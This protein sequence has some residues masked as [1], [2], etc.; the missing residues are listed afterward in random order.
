MPEGDTIFRAARTLDRALAGSA[1]ARFETALPALARVDEDAP[2]AGR[3]VESVTARGKHQ[4]MRFSARPGG[5]GGPLVL[6]THMRMSGSW[7]LYRHGERWQRPRGAMR[8]LVETAAWVAVGFDVPVAEWLD[9]RGL[10]RQRE[11]RRLG[12]D[13]LAADFD[14][15]EA[16]R[17]L[18][19][20]DAAAVGDALLDQ[21]ALAG[22]GNVFKSEILFVAGVSPFRSVA[23]LS[24]EEL[25]SIVAVSRRLLRANAGPGEDGV[26]W[27]AGAR[28]TTGAANPAAALWVYGR[29]GDPCRRCATPVAYRKQGP[30]ARG[31]YWC[32]RC[33]PG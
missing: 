12:P 24:D 11:L 6:R 26:A 8:V 19:A 33:Q 20:R 29:G 23:S 4:L 32:P 10:E 18:R 31:T 1:V 3:L 15:A 27:H 17:R 28:R 5:G 14:A 7:H 9:E 22:I 16:E 13:L 25:R 2:I 21:A 30:D